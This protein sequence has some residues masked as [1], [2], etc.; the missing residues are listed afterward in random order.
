MPKGTSR[1]IKWRINLFFT[2]M[3]ASFYA[4]NMHDKYLKIYNYLRKN[5]TE[6]NVISDFS[7]LGLDLA[8]NKN[9]KTCS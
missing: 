3:S 2:F 9:M 1:I 7:P 8:Y 4:Q 5:L 6:P